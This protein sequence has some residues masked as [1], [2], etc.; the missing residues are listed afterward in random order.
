MGTQRP[1]T[2]VHQPSTRDCHNDYHV[3]TKRRRT[4]NGS[5]SS[6]HH[7]PGA[8]SLD[9]LRELAGAPEAISAGGGSKHQASRGT[10]TGTAPGVTLQPGEL[11]KIMKNVEFGRQ[12]FAELIGPFSTLQGMKDE[13]EDDKERAEEQLSE[14][15]ERIRELQSRVISSPLPSSWMSGNVGA[16]T[17]DTRLVRRLHQLGVANHS[18]DASS[19]SGASTGATGHGNM[20]ASLAADEPLRSVGWSLALEPVLDAV[21]SKLAS[22]GIPIHSI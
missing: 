21:D 3:G 6:S 7:G 14:A 11:E 16:A 1:S 15:N 5:S 12:L 4:R 2:H 17:S 10:S 13:A 9:R 20:S 18:R 22:F 19:R 8:I